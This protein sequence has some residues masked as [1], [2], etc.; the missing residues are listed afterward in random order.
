MVSMLLHSDCHQGS[1]VP[2]PEQGPKVHCLAD[3]AWLPSRQA[4]R[5]TLSN[6]ITANLN[7]Y[8]ISYLRQNN[9]N[10]TYGDWIYVSTTKTIVAGIVMPFLGEASRLMGLRLA[11]I[12]GCA[13]FR[14]TSLIKYH[15]VM[16]NRTFIQYWIPAHPPGLGGRPLAHRHHSWSLAW[17]RLQSDLRPGHWRCHDGECM[18]FVKVENV[19]W[20]TFC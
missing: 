16:I 12:L 2:S 18:Q 5:C 13:I 17:H 10:I 20:L 3:E 14:Y 7:S 1:I 15:Q 4:N 9:D 11:L 8:V 19:T 6:T